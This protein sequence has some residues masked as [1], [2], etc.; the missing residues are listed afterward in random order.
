MSTTVNAS[1]SPPQP[2]P[3]EAAILLCFSSVDFVTTASAGVAMNHRDNS[4]CRRYACYQCSVRLRRLL[5]V[6]EDYALERWWG[7]ICGSRRPRHT[8]TTTKRRT[9][10]LPY[11]P[12]LHQGPSF[13]CACVPRHSARLNAA[14][15]PSIF[16]NAAVESGESAVAAAGAPGDAG[17]AVLAAVGR[18]V[19]VDVVALVVAVGVGARVALVGGVFREEIDEAVVGGDRSAVGAGRVVEEINVLDEP[20]AGVAATDV[21]SRSAVVGWVD[22]AQA[23]ARSP[24][25]HHQAATGIVSVLHPQRQRC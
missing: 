14:A 2:R 19:G 12:T 3:S 22:V 8:R 9:H 5:Y 15:L 17:V 18:A 6:H 7:G 25:Q 24:E 23:A 16:A 10:F 4:V 21:D 20:A 11:T 13:A 1:S